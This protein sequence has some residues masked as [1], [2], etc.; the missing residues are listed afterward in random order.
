M[1]KVVQEPDRIQTEPFSEIEKSSSNRL[2]SYSLA[3]LLLVGYSILAILYGAYVRASFSGDGCGTNWPNC[4]QANFLPSGSLKSFIEFSH[5]VSAQ[6][7]L[8]LTV[9]LYWFTRAKKPEYKE[10]QRW[11]LWATFFTLVEGAVGAGLI[12]FGLTAYKD[13]VHRTFAMSLHLVTTFALL[14]SL[15]FAALS[16][17]YKERVEFKGQGAVL[18]IFSFGAF[19]TVILGISGAISALGTMLRVHDQVLEQALRPTADYLDRLRVAHPFVAVAALV[20]IVVC[21]GLV[22]AIRP[23]PMVRKASRVLLGLFAVQMACGLLNIWIKA[24]VWMQVIHLLLADLIWM[25]LVSVGYFAL[26]AEKAS[27]PEKQEEEAPE[28]PKP[29]PRELVKAYV[30]VTK[31]RI[32]SLLLFTTVTAMFAA[33]KGWPGGSLLL[34][35][36]VGG[37]CSAGAANAINMIIDRDIDGSMDRTAKRPT[38]TQIIP[39]RNVAIFATILTVGSFSMLWAAANLLAALMSLAG[40]LT[41]VVL[42]TMMLKRRTWQNIVWGGAAGCFPPLVGW[43]A[44]TNQLNPLA[45]CLFGII[46]MWTPVHFWALA[47]LIKD[48]YAAAGVP[49]LPVVRG[50]RATV[51]QI[52][53]YGILTAL[54]SAIPLAQRE[55]G[56]LYLGTIVIL[57]FGLLAR[58][59]TLLRTE[60]R[61]HARQLFKFSM[62][63][64]ALLFLMIA[65][66]RAVLS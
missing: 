10:T 40:L 37:Y 2:T 45:L 46:F 47:L 32:I 30:A 18:S 1:A 41:Y 24:P 5:R 11:L 53:F 43:A 56:W 35:V 48:D 28:L 38:V 39:T 4:G 15:A 16:S 34:W 65:V 60:D 21:A 9:G 57:N 31:P 62:A 26:T 22:S 66:D 63:Y 19:W 8:P 58:C 17:V 3:V 50:D 12:K 23:Y 59:F 54:V 36:M 7:I 14:A 42:Y 55:V 64:L 52:T 6:L 27:L 25:A 51:V 20:S 61:D 33:A 44:V 49:M 13:T 29:S